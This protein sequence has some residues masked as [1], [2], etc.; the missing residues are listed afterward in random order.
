M[1]R[2]KKLLHIC[3]IFAFINMMLCPVVHVLHDQYFGH[4]VV[5][6]PLNSIVQKNA[7][8]D[9][10]Q[11]QEVMLCSPLTRDTIKSSFLQNTPNVLVA[12]TSNNLSIVTTVRLNL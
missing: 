3:F 7:L 11:H 1:S 6:F 12:N 9:A 8:G 2:H 4:E 10:K 5:N